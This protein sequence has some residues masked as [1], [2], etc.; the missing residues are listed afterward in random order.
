MLNNRPMPQEIG[1]SP[2]FMV[3]SYRQNYPDY[4]GYQYSII[5]NTSKKGG[6]LSKHNF[7]F[8]LFVN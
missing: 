5:S 6:I 4:G 3:N 2:K 8:R 1:S 7:T